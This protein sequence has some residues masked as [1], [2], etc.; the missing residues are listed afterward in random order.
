MKPCHCWRL[1]HPPRLNS[2]TNAFWVFGS[3]AMLFYQPLISLCLHPHQGELWLRR[4]PAI[5][6]EYIHQWNYRGK[7]HAAISKTIDPQLSKLEKQVQ[8]GEGQRKRTL[9][10]RCTGTFFRLPF[11]LDFPSLRQCVTRGEFERPADVNPLQAQQQPFYETNSTGS[12][13]LGLLCLDWTSDYSTVL[14]T[15]FNLFYSTEGLMIKLQQ[16]PLRSST[17]LLWKQLDLWPTSIC[18]VALALNSCMVIS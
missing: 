7:K 16:Q 4:S 8:K 15:G 5:A 9:S 11:L 13:C 3:G 14:P 1:L 10:P 12:V 17:L 18:S 2:L 6:T